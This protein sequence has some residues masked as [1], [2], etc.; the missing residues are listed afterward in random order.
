MNLVQGQMVDQSRA[1]LLTWFDHLVK[2]T[3]VA[4]ISTRARARFSFKADNLTRDPGWWEGLAPREQ[5]MA[6]AALSS[7]ACKGWGLKCEK[8]GIPFRVVSV[9]PPQA[10]P[11]RPMWSCSS[12]P[13]LLIFSFLQGLI[14][15]CH[16]VGV[17]VLTCTYQSGVL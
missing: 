1:N 10:Q 11:P 17:E 5:N 16:A 8:R 9:E 12:G 2:S 13:F 6:T 3:I 7:H 14:Y 15:F 4:N